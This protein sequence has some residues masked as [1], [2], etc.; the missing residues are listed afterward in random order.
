[1][2]PAGGWLNHEL[3]H[4]PEGEQGETGDEFEH[5]VPTVRGLSSAC[6]TLIDRR[7]I[8]AQPVGDGEPRYWAN[9]SD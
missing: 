3:Q 8:I 9:R 1:M 6:L 2:N 5:A 4:A 7:R